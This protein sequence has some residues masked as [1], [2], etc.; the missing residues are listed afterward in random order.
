MGSP[1]AHIVRVAGNGTVVAGRLVG[2]ET[3][4]IAATVE[5]ENEKKK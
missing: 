2:I 5:V 3:L 4:A 1:V